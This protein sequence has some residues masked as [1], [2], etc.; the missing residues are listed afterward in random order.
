M[1]RAAIFANTDIDFVILLKAE[2]V[3][4]FS[5]F[6]PVLNHHDNAVVISTKDS[7][8]HLL[9]HSIRY[10]HAKEDSFLDSSQLFAHGHWGNTAY[11][12]KAFIPS[13][14]LLMN[15]PK[16]KIRIGID[17]ES[18]PYQFINKWKAYHSN[19]EF[20]DVGDVIKN[21]MLV[22]DEAEINRIRI[23]SKLA[24][25]SMEK[26]IELVHAGAN[27]MEITTEGQYVMRKLWEQSYS[28]YEI[29]G[30]GGKQ[31]GIIDDF[32]CWVLTNQRI[33]YGCDCPQKINVDTA[34]IVLPMVWATIGGYHAENERTL[35]SKNVSDDK[36]KA[37]E[38]MLHAR[39]AIF[40]NLKPG[41]TFS[42]LYEYAKALFIQFGF[43]EILPGRVGHGIGLHPHEYPSIE[44]ANHIILEEG[45]VLTVEP[46]LMEK[47]WGGVRHSDTVVVTEDSFEILT[48]TDR[49]TLLI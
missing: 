48:Q 45:M 14:L 25:S 44:A 43:E 41:N 46:G 5:G 4:Y 36:K 13:L 3:Y 19:C 40:E 6:N 38:A 35:I 17:F 34:D 16:E 18:T 11:V 42:S 37:Y 10:E 2:F 33:S 49:G 31:G 28:D 47:T 20:V 27:E 39:E 9:T 1:N 26:M 12:H 29:S 24:D 15:A 22:K 7:N 8:V 30:F 32:H 23:A 21:A